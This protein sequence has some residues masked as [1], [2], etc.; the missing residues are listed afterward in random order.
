MTKSLQNF[1]NILFLNTIKC[2]QKIYLLSCIKMESFEQKEFSEIDK[3]N[4]DL[5]DLNNSIKSVKSKEKESKVPNEYLVAKKKFQSFLSSPA[6]SNDIEDKELSLYNFDSV[7]R[8]KNIK[9]HPRMLVAELKTLRKDLKEEIDKFL[10]KQPP[11]VLGLQKTLNK[12]LELGGSVQ[13]GK[14]V[15]TMYPYIDL[16]KLQY[17]LK[18]TWVKLVERRRYY[19]GFEEVRYKIKE[20]W[21]LWPQTIA[22]IYS[23]R[24]MYHC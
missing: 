13:T 20:D 14:N 6:D 17:I 5:V 7:N 24:E 1:D 10:Q 4:T 3:I 8:W 15:R 16:R 18:W 2:L 23:I 11:D 22:A 21:I 12:R 19:E 9:P